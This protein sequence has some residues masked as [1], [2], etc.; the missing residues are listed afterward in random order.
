MTVAIIWVGALAVFDKEMSVGALIAF[1][2]LSGRVTAPLV[3]LVSL[4]HEYQ[5][6]ALSVRMLGNVMNAPKEHNVGGVHNPLKGKITFEN[7]SFKYTADGPQVI[8]TFDLNIPKGATLGI[9]GR[10]GSGKTTLTKLLQALYPLQSGLIKVDGIDIRE[11]DKAHLRTSIGV[12]LQENY[13]FHGTVREN[14]CLTKKTATMEEVIYAT[15]LAGADEFVQEL[16]KG[17]D[18]EL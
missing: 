6:T 9:V 12:V 13:F 17:Y 7:I 2:M 5:Q 18:T 16:S 3:K 10:S 8:K 4:V 11:I 15:R 1:Q 14:I